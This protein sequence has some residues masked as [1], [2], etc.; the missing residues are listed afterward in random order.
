[1]KRA[2]ISCIKL[3]DTIILNIL[4]VH[5]NILVILINNISTILNKE[6]DVILLSFSHHAKIKHKLEIDTNITGYGLQIY[7]MNV[8]YANEVYIAGQE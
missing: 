4:I 3:P 1:M 6:E 8:Y 2:V 7:T 5:N